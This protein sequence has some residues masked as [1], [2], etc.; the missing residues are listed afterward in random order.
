MCKVIL[1]KIC[2]LI[3]KI[4]LCIIL[5]IKIYYICVVKFNIWIFWNLYVYVFC[6]F[7]DELIV[8]IGDIL[9][10]MCFLYIYVCM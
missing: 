4:V 2:R 1:I 8:V 10:W 6:S 9:I 5:K 3:K 7:F